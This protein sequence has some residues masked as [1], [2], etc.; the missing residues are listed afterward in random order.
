MS[1][2]GPSQE[3]VLARRVLLDALD[4]LGAHR[5]AIVLVG[6]QAVYLH[7]GD[8]DLAVAPTTTDA[9]IAL[10]PDRLR[11]E[12]LLEDAL[13]TAGFLPGS[14]PGSWVGAHGVAVD[15]M[16]PEALSGSGGRRGARLPR[17][18]N[19]VARRTTG[20]EAAL[21]DF[22]E[23]ELS[24]LEDTDERT[25][26]IRVAGPAAL[27]IAKVI[28]VEERRSQARLQAKDGLDVLRLLQATDPEPLARR[29]AELAV[30]PLSRETTHQAIQS[31]RDHG[32]D[33]D[34]P[35]ATLAVQAVGVLEDPATIAGS[36]TALI[37]E[38]LSAYDHTDGRA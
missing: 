38:L 31:L 23:R 19:R 26:A 10:A 12:P 16:V 5:E 8:A 22:E 21:V 37:E 29:L 28:K 1:Q 18:G 34:G 30:H 13:R 33:P 3:Y 6:A 35:L 14:N 2:G 36:L 24:A 9:D 7:T 11:D 25:F 32:T 17:H 27:L 4:A 20:L 15:L